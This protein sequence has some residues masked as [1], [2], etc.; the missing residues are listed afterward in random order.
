MVQLTIS[1][2]H[3]Y[4]SR[5]CLHLQNYQVSHRIK[6]LYKSQVSRFTFELIFFVQRT[7]VL[8]FALSIYLLLSV[9]YLACCVHSGTSSA[10]LQRFSLKDAI[11]N[12]LY[13]IKAED[14]SICR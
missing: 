8:P 12:W 5:L 6:S 14:G 1:H 13:Y 3:L 4:L 9:L 7:H 10:E 11:S 2:V